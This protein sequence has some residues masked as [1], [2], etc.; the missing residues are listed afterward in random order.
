MFSSHVNGRR[1]ALTMREADKKFVVGFCATIC[2]TFYMSSTCLFL[3]RM[4]E[5]S[6]LEEL[7]LRVFS[8]DSDL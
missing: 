3:R 8:L 5:G 1:I 7:R 6:D 4:Y 2:S